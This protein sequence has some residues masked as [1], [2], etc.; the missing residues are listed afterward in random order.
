[1][2]KISME[3]LGQDSSYFSQA[4]WRPVLDVSFPQMLPAI[5][6]LGGSHPSK[7]DNFRQNISILWLRIARQ[8]LNS[9]NYHNYKRKMLRSTKA[10]NR[11][12]MIRLR[13]PPLGV[14]RGSWVVRYWTSR[15]RF[16]ASFAADQY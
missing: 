13:A 6:A 3:S 4:F 12:K 1:M 5:T 10:L 8:Y 11:M 14:V 2:T 15:G 9:S 7:T 16:I